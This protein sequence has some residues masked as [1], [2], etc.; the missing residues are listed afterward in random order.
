MFREL[1]RRKINWKAL[2][3]AE[4]EFPYNPPGDR[5]SFSVSPERFLADLSYFVRVFF[6]QYFRLYSV[7][8]SF[9]LLS[10]Y[11]DFVVYS[12]NLGCL[13]HYY[14][15]KLLGRR[16]LV[17]VRNRDFDGSLAKRPYVYK[18]TL[19]KK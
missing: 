11:V 3:V 19:F 15:Y 13:L 5:L 10:L 4:V 1:R 12:Y 6:P 17:A 16:S 18:E 7:N 8:Q 9:L 2:R 14:S